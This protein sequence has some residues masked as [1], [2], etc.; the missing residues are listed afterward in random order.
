MLGDHP[1]RERV[2]HVLSHA[3]APSTADSYGAHFA[4][5]VRW[6]ESR[7]DQPS[8]LPAS[9]G[10]VLRWL[11]DDV[12]RGDR[13][14]KDSLQPYLSAIN[15]LH[16]DLGYEEPALGHLI[17]RFRSG[18]G[19]LQTDRGRA[20]QRVYLPPPVVERVL[21]WALALDLSAATKRGRSA[22]RAAVATVFTFCFFARGATGSQLR[23]TD[24]RR[25]VAGVTVTLEYEKGKRTAGAARSITI[26]PGAIPGLEALLAKW[27]A[28]RGPRGERD[29]YY[30]LPGE[31]RAFPASAVDG[32][33]REILAHLDR[34]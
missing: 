20:A 13:V 11:A 27:E 24:V 10:T 6:C 18:L 9:T 19:H 7:P 32:W 23:C 28:F 30:A 17:Q 26:P 16:R 1:E 29:C 22:F 34:A 14:K 4:R 33:L 8:P 31:R 3:L 12:T 25:S 15:S 2:L 5:F 21:E